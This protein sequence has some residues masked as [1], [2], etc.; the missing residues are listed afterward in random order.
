L[1][2]EKMKLLPFQPFDVIVSLPPW[3]VCRR[4]LEN[5]GGAKPFHGDVQ[6]ASFKIRRNSIYSDPFLPRLHGVLVAVDG[7]TRITIKMKMYMLTK[8]YLFFVTLMVAGLNLSGSLSYRHDLLIVA[9]IAFI[10]FIVLRFEAKESRQAFMMFLEN[11][12]I[13]N[14]GV[15]SDAAIDAAPHPLTRSSF[16][17]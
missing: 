5:V 15:V 1:A 14:N 6:E 16:A 13:T 7:G 17:N 9:L 8:L 12:I 3:E 11:H 2:E 10:T 4:L